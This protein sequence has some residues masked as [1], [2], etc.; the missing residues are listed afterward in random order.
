MLHLTLGNPHLSGLLGK[1]VEYY[2]TFSKSC[3]TYL[4]KPLPLMLQLMI[5]VIMH[6]V[7]PGAVPAILS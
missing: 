4:A 3:S 1:T 2:R 6:T 7:L 5:L